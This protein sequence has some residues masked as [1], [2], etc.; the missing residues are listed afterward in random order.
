MYASGQPGGHQGGLAYLTPLLHK[1]SLV[2]HSHFP[3]ISESRVFSFLLLLLH[4]ATL[5]C[6]DAQESKHMHVNICGSP[7][8]SELFLP[9][10]WKKDSGPLRHAG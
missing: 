3:R 2:L 8:V 7:A 10:R 4:Q 1:G 9:P 6:A 5:L